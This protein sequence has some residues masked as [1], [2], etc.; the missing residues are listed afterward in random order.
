MNHITIAHVFD[1]N[2]VHYIKKVKNARWSVAMQFAPG[3]A[4]V[5]SFSGVAVEYMTELFYLLKTNLS[6]STYNFCFLEPFV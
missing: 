4:G 2:A 3:S 1:M 5:I 6:K